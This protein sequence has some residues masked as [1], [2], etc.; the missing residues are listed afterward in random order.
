[1]LKTL[2]QAKRLYTRVK[3]FCN[4][5]LGHILRNKVVQYLYCKFFSLSKKGR[6]FVIIF[7]VFCSWFIYLKCIFRFENFND[8]EKTAEYLRKRFPKGSSGKEFVKTIKRAGAECEI[9]LNPNG[10][11]GFDAP[12]HTKEEWFCDY[13]HLEFS[14]HL[15]IRHYVGVYLDKDDKIIGLYAGRE[16]ETL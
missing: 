5:T 7:V 9:V 13:G 11:S 8:G 6:I 2:E 12:D 10:P 15:I 14:W 16:P 4:R 3:V 1:M